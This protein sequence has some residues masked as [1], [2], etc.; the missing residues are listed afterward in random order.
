M[1]K[2]YLEALIVSA[3]VG[4]CIRAVVLLM[5]GQSLFTSVEN[6]FY[7]AVIAI[8]SCTIS[9]LVH[10]NVL[11]NSRYSFVTKYVISSILIVSIYVIGNL[12]VGGMYVFYQIQF[13]SYGAAIV[14]I[15]LPLIYYFNK[16]M[17]RFNDFLQLKKSQHVKE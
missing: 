8:V 1:K 12:Y 14:L 10:V 17:I 11:T 6:Y 15:S 13:Y 5:M 9:F 3:L 16:R 7:S 2:F 4:V